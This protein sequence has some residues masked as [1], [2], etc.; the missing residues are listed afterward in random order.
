MGL[1]KGLPICKVVY[2][3]Y[4]F[5][6]LSNHREFRREISVMEVIGLRDLEKETVEGEDEESLDGTY[7]KL[8]E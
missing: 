1:S 2:P 4:K 7:E 6:K 5:K 8:F 3:V